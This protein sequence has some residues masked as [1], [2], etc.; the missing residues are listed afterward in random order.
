MMKFTALKNPTV[1]KVLSAL[2]V[3]VFGFILLNL[4]FLFDFIFQ[5]LVDGAVKLF[6]PVDFN[7]AWYWFPPMKHVMFVAIIGLI[8]WY[9]FRSK[10]GVLYKAIYMTVPL[11]VVFVSLGMFLYRWPLAAYLLGGLF[12][13]GVL[14]FFYRSKQPWLYYYALILVSLVMLITGLL[15][16]EI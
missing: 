10:L 9:I 7:A 11:A 1:K 15:G 14:Y 2:A 12:F 6:T 16:M 4:T 13:I 8:S 5:T 3:A